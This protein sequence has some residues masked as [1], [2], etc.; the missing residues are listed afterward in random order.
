[1]S[2]TSFVPRFLSSSRTESRSV[3]STQTSEGNRSLPSMIS[4]RAAGRAK[5]TPWL[6]ALFHSLKRSS[7]SDSSSSASAL[8]SLA[9]R[10]MRTVVMPLIILLCSDLNQ[11]SSASAFICVNQ[12]LKL[13][14]HRIIRI[15]V[16]VKPFTSLPSIPAGHHQSLE[17]R[18]RSE[19]V[20]AELVEHYVRD[21]VRGIEANKIQQRE[22][23]H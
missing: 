22:R 4:S 20:F 17:Q 21:V 7:P 16:I 3:T 13:P 14:R 1:M 6:R 12:R 18:R 23:A 5:G 8:S 11:R 19:A 2:E 15:G 9:L 10:N